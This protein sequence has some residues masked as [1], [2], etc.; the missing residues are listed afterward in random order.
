MP[1]MSYRKMRSVTVN[2]LCELIDCC[3]MQQA[4][5]VQQSLGGRAGKV[6]QPWIGTLQHSTHTLNHSEHLRIGVIFEELDAPRARFALLDVF[7]P[8]HILIINRAHAA[9]GERVA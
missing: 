8:L 9:F 1:L 7:E 6:N 5:S 3:Q 2:E 4:N